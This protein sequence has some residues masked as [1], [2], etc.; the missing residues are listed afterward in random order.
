MTLGWRVGDVLTNE[1]NTSTR[2]DECYI[3][4]GVSKVWHNEGGRDD[5]E[6]QCTEEPY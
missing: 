4:W 6:T 1:T 3:Y 5:C 2:V